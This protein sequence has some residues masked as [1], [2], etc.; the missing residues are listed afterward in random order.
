[1][2]TMDV[3][4]EKGL[5]PVEL[6]AKDALSLINGTS[7]MLSYSIISLSMLNNRPITHVIYCVSLDAFKGSLTR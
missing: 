6:N 2:D 5:I 7:Q 3:L 1:M 4:T